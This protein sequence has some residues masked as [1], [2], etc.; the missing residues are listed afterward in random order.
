MVRDTSTA[1]ITRADERDVDASAVTVRSVTLD[2]FAE[3]AA[4]PD[5]IKMDIEG[6]ELSALRGAR[7]LLGRQVPPRLLIEF[8]G[9]QLK[10]EGCAMLNDLGY[11]FRSVSGDIWVHDV[12][13]MERHVLCVPERHRP[14]V[15]VLPMSCLLFERAHDPQ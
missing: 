9:D 1:H 15:A 14:W 4:A 6:A 3:T 13:P 11:A 8:H 7:H 10:R 12:L 5:F 2:D